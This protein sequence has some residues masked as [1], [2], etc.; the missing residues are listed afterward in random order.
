MGG[1]DPHSRFIHLRS[2]VELL[3]NWAQAARREGVV[4]EDLCG[5][6]ATGMLMARLDGTKADLEELKGAVNGDALERVYER[7][8]SAE[9]S[10]K[11]LV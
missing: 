10:I 11:R 6:V 1:I 7:L 9:N 8:L 3:E 4:G 2:I 5:A